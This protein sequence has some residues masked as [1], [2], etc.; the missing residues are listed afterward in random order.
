M[1]KEDI[2]QICNTTVSKYNCPRCNILY[3]SLPCYKSEQHL[4]CSESFYRENVIQEIALVRNDQE[5][6]ESSK[7]MI[8][9]LGRLDETAG[10]QF[11]E[12]EESDNNEEVDSDD[13]ENIRSL[14]ER[15][16]V[17]N[18]DNAD[19]VWQQLTDEERNEFQNMLE[20]GDISQIMPIVEP[21]WERPY[22]VELIQSASGNKLS[23]GERNL[24]EK[25][26][27][28]KKSIKGFKEICSKEPSPLMK[29]NVANVLAAYA[30]TFRYFNGDFKECTREAVNCLV[31]ICGNL[32]HNTVYDS[33]K[34]AVASVCSECQ[35]EQLPVDNET[36]ILLAQDV[37]QL[38]GGPSNCGDKY[39]KHFVMTALS[40][41]HHLLGLVRKADKRPNEFEKATRGE[42]SKKF[43]DEI[44][45]L[46]YIESDRL[47]SCSKK[48]DFM[49]SYAK[50]YL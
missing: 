8:D 12:D 18:L 11:N 35:Q 20:S 48:I 42:F 32:K 47:K 40:D 28:I 7:A 13:G 38:F 2:C 5:S 29:Y 45:D 34:L 24:I 27:P 16:G 22:Q 33:E 9:I 26:P 44:G 15:L 3:C 10:L 43:S 6:A 19:A 25:C 4:Q 31:S 49:L 1:D 30:L 37:K 21:W 36:S 39:R 41:V 46:I 14:A 50:D 23:A 17:I